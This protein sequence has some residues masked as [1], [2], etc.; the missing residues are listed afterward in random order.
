MQRGKLFYMVGTSVQE[1]RLVGAPTV[2]AE[3]LI[4]HIYG[5]L[6]AFTERAWPCVADA[7]R[8]AHRVL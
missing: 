2:I 7:V 8:G 1:L 5:V 6:V 3:V 4:Q